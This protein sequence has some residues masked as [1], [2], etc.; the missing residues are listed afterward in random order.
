M[1]RAEV[2]W[3]SSGSGEHVGILDKFWTWTYRHGLTDL[4]DGMD[5]AVV[6]VGVGQGVGETS[7]F[8]RTLGLVARLWRK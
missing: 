6:G 8:G 5:V 7:Q 2:G 4:A 1:L 3:C